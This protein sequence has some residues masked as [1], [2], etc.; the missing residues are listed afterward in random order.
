[1]GENLLKEGWGQ[2]GRR[3]PGERGEG[4]GCCCL[5]QRHAHSLLYWSEGVGVQAKAQ[6]EQSPASQ[7]PE[8]ERRVVKPELVVPR[9]RECQPDCHDVRD[10]RE[11]RREP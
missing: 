9:A 10:K 7:L 1:M 8:T 11:Q 2:G 5:R 4:R 3:G 6:V